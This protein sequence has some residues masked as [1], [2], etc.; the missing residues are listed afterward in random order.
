MQAPIGCPMTL[1]F[2]DA[3]EK[4]QTVFI[5]SESPSFWIV[6]LPTVIDGTVWQPGQT[7]SANYAFA[8]NAYSAETAVLYFMPKFQLLFLAYPDS[9]SVTPLR[10]ESRTPCRIP[11]TASIQEKALRGLV[12]DISNHGCQFIVRIP[13]TFKPYRVSVLT[14]ILLSLSLYGQR[15]IAQLKGK[16]RNT[17]IDEANIILG[18]EFYAMEESFSDRLN[19]FIQDLSESH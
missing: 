9:F 5:G 12:T 6:R 1:H 16:V 3:S 10:R 2:N 18:V 17:N 15:D 19:G 13:T 11:A 7:L 8:G 4:I 14:D